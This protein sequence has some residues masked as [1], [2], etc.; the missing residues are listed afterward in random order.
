MSAFLSEGLMFA[1][2]SEGL[3]FAFLSEGLMFAIFSCN[4]W[5]CF[6]LNQCIFSPQAHTFCDIGF[7]LI[8]ST[9]FDEVLVPEK[10][11]QISSLLKLNAP[12]I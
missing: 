9:G 11:K 6:R 12:S 4:F 2:L 7:F 3:M 5:C 1:F 10:R 8:F